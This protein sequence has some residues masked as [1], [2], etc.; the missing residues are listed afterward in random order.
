MLESGSSA[1]D[2]VVEA[3]VVLEDDPRLNAGTGSRMRLDGRTQMDAALMDSRMEIGGVAVIEAVKN[4][5]RVA[6]DVMGT[7]HVLLAGKDATDFARTQGHPRYDPSTPESFQRLEESRERIR[8]GRL[9]AYARRWRR[10]GGHDTVGAVA[11]DR[12]GRFA[13]GSSTGGTAFMMPGRI[14]DS[15]LVGS[16]LYAGPAGAVTATGIGEE[17]IRRVLSKFVYDKIADGLTP[18]AAANRGLALFP[19]SVPIG[20]LAVGPGGWGVAS[21]RPMA[22]FRPV[23]RRTL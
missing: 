22:F 6:R 7:P 17:I 4:P 13:A 3:I 20:L 15:P 16:G 10:F 11:R 23:S 9:P 19:K 5:I 14:G 18:Q 21:N 2:A 12:L 1:L 8:E